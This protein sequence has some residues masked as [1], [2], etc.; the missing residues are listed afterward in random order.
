MPTQ[1]STGLIGIGYVLFFQA[2]I[3]AAAQAFPV[4]APMASM[5][6]GIAPDYVGYFSTVV[7]A[8]ALVASNGLSG[9]LRRLGS[10]RSAAASLL[11]SAS[12]L[13]VLALSNSMLGLV[14][15]AVVLG[16][17]Y[18]PV[19]PLGSRVLLR[20]TQGFRRNLVFSLKQT[21]VAIGGAAAAALLPVIA[22][23][24]GWRAGMVAIAILLLAMALS[25]WPVRRRLGDDGD[26][27][28][29][30]RFV[31]PFKPARAL[32]TERS[33]R[34]LS[35]SMFAFSVT[36][37]SVM[38]VYVT[39]LWSHA[40][41]APGMAAA[42][43]SLAMVSS[44][45]GRVG[46]G[47]VADGRNAIMVL[48]LLAG[49]GA[50]AVPAMLLLIPG[51]SIAFSVLVSIVLGVGPLSWSGVFLAE[52]ANEGLLRGGDQAVVSITAGMMVFGYLGGVVGPSVFSLSALLVGDYWP[53]VMLV[54]LSLAASA[55]L[56]LRQS[57]RRPRFS[58]EPR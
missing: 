7:F 27:A 56:L 46:W 21:S 45:V 22:I 57:A 3:I 51:T 48:A 55:V 54:A 6:L 43:L 5:S 11:I 49:I 10:L 52:I 24:F 38:S 20:L 37:F 31:G 32:L 42:M 50:V 28:A 29:P 8:S 18:G 30:I 13:I 25:T 16:V 4:L 19:N 41:L 2:S 36:Q 15:G 17:A 44:M 34:A 39:F 40:G 47:W 9:L 33:L 14:A 53:G 26:L 23:P 35:V 1:L 12:G 58:G